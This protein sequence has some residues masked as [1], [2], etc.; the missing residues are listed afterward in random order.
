MRPQALTQIY[1]V[2][3]LIIKIISTL[4]LFNEKL[5]LVECKKRE[6]ACLLPSAPLKLLC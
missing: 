6:A 1:L 4:M 2:A 3:G 5:D